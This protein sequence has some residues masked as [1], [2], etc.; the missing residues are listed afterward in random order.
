MP[1]FCGFRNGKTP[2]GLLFQVCCNTGIC[3]DARAV[4]PSRQKNIAKRPRFLGRLCVPCLCKKPFRASLLGTCRLNCEPCG[5]LWNIEESC[6]NGL[7]GSCFI[8]FGE[9]FLPQRPTQYCGF[10]IQNKGRT[11][12][13][14][15]SLLKKEF[16]RTDA[17]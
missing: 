1:K 12:W 7:R 14:L 13:L 4:R 6:A 11:W 5:L 2:I 15:R 10:W 16:E 9:Y 3:T 8:Y 17:A